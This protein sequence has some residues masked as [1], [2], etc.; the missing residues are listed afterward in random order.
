MRFEAP[1]LQIVS[2]DQTI[3]FGVDGFE[4]D[5]YQSFVAGSLRTLGNWRQTTSATLDLT[6]DRS[7]HDYYI[8]DAVFEPVDPDWERGVGVSVSLRRNEPSTSEPDP[9]R[10]CFYISVET[11]AGRSPLSLAIQFFVVASSFE[12]FKDVLVIDDQSDNPAAEGNYQDRSSFLRH[13]ACV[14]PKQ[15]DWS[16]VHHRELLD[17]FMVSLRQET[18]QGVVLP[19]R[20]RSQGGA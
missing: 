12:H 15:F 13:A 18:N 11:G 7:L 1:K 5:A 9:R 2:Y 14:F 8:H 19:A 17:H 4:H 3:Y 6:R 20:G 16:H 10:F